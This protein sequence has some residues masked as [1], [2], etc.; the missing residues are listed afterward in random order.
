M[1]VVV[2]VVVVATV[3]VT[4]PSTL[5]IGACWYHGSVSGQGLK[6]PPKFDP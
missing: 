6:V 5:Q 2:T 1:I 3:V 4:V